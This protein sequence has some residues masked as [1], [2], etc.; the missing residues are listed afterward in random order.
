MKAITLRNIPT[1]LAQRIEAE[2]S[3]TGASLNAT[4][5][6]LLHEALLPGTAGGGAKRA[7]HDLDHLAGTWSKEEADEFDRYLVESRG[8]DQELTRLEWLR[9]DAQ[10]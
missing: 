5:L 9:E 1:E 2:A 10:K 7:Y 4:V 3:R 6:R 8:L